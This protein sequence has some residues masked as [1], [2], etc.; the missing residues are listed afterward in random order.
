MSASESD[1]PQ[2]LGEGQ[3][4]DVVS[5]RERKWMVQGKENPHGLEG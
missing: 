5:V 2:P 4:L 1:A 3:N